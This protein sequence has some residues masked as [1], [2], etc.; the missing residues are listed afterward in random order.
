MKVWVFVEG[1][2]DKLGLEALWT[3][4]RRRL[5]AQRWGIAV[6]PLANKANF[7]KKFGARAAEKLVGSTSDVVV[8]LP[9]L[10]PVTP[11]QN[12]VFKHDDVNE[13]KEVQRRTVRDALQTTHRIDGDRADDLLGRLLP[14]VLKHDFEMLLLA[15]VDALRVQLG[16]SENLGNWRI[17]VEE[18]NLGKP[19][20][21][22]VEE[23]FLT[24]SKLRKAYRD[25]RDA[26]AILRRVNDLP[27]ILR[28][29]SGQWTCP[30]F[31]AVL[32]WVGERTGVPACALD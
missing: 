2:S 9:D 10:H 19:P 13:L 26:P 1:A 29:N 23:L 21:R 24:K 31:V 14:S 17:P 12:T 16:T 3:D 28:T 4:W 7:L 6:V 32:K 30:E 15:A 8:G 27:A 18:Q 20:K 5:G 25:T 22:V 11:F